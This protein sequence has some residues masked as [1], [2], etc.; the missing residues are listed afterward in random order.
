MSQ[1]TNEFLQFKSAD[2][3]VIY[4]TMLADR[5]L[6]TK[7]KE[8]EEK[9]EKYSLSAFPRLSPIPGRLG[10]LLRNLH[11]DVEVRNEMAVNFIQ[12]VEEGSKRRFIKNLFIWWNVLDSFSKRR[13]DI[14]D[15]FCEE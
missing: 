6:D 1:G 4:N 10:W 8:A 13:V 9:A 5:D 14:F 2:P 7:E 11:P 12:A 3:A 15:I